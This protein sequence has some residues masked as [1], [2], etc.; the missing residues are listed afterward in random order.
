M[1]GEEKMIGLCGTC[2]SK[3]FWESPRG[4]RR[5]SGKQSGLETLIFVIFLVD[6]ET[7]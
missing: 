5:C 7:M 2:W 6:V 3:M 4:Y 1:E